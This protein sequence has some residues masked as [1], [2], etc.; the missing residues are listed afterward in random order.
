MQAGHVT[1]HGP[2]DPDMAFLIRQ[3]DHDLKALELAADRIGVLEAEKVAWER[4]KTILIVQARRD[5]KA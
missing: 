1:P 5:A 3:H 4:E 2:Q